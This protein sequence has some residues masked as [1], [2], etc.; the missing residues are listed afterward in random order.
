MNQAGEEVE[1]SSLFQAVGE[2]EGAEVGTPCQGAGVGA[3]SWR[4]QAEVEVAE[5]LGQMQPLSLVGEVGVG[6]QGE[7]W[8]LS[9]AKG[10]ARV[11]VEGVLGERWPL[12]LAEG[13]GVA[14]ARG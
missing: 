2:G 10:V 8:S 4:S 7:R 12:G 1:E 5:V 6:V 13:V 3:G 11:G 9:L 14:G